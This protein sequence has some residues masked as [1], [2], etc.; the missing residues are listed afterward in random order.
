[1]ENIAISIKNIKNIFILFQ[2]H[3]ILQIS[4][5]ITKWKNNNLIKLSTLSRGNNQIFP[6]VAVDK[7]KFSILWLTNGFDT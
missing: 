2:V 5:K 3:K 7:Q 6:V 4:G 1:M